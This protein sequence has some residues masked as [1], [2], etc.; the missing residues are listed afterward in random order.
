M[1]F[2]PWL[3]LIVLPGFLLGADLLA[4][5][6]TQPSVHKAVVPPGYHV[7]ST[8][9][10]SAFCQPADD[11]WVKS[12]L[13]SVSPT[14]RPTT[15]P[16]DLISSLQQHRADLTSQMMQDLALSDTKTI[17]NFLDTIML[18]DLQKMEAMKPT[19]YYFPATHDQVVNLLG[20]GWSDPRFHYLR[21][22][23][24]LSYLPGFHLSADKP[25]D[26]ILWW[27][28]I[29]DGDTTGTRRDALASQVKSLE[30]GIADNVSLYS[31]NQTEHLFEAFVHQNVFVPLKL[32]ARLQ[33]VDFGASNIFAVKF[34]S[35]VTGLSRQY[36]MEQ[37]IGRPNESRPYLHL[38]LINGIDPS[39]IRPEYVPVYDQAILPKGAYVINS[40]MLKCGDSALAKVLPAWRAQSPQTP[41]QLIQSIQSATGVDLTPFMQPDFSNP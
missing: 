27:I 29:H 22:A 3:A 35:M 30:A 20:G 28:E 41:Q 1:I 14:T 21:F 34:A 2:R 18:P 36:W 33:W 39:Q 5:P 24:D 7:V 15:L 19:I 11:D 31:S 9:D 32:P 16:S 10:R 4:D 40:L 23:N 12:A 13:Q 6:A 37:L 17:D 38:D 25:N 8:R 26:D